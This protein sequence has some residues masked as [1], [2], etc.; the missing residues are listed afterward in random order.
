MRINLNKFM[1]SGFF[2]PILATLLLSCAPSVSLHF[3][4]EPFGNNGCQSPRSAAI[5]K[6]AILPFAKST[7]RSHE[8]INPISSNTVTAMNVQNNM[9]R[10][11]FIENDGELATTASER[12]LT[13][14]GKFEIVER[15]DI[16]N[17]I[18]EQKFMLSGLISEDDVYK[19]GNLLGADAILVGRVNSAYSYKQ[20]VSNSSGA[21]LT[22]PVSYVTVSVKLI[23]TRSGKLLWSCVGQRNSLNYLN[24][25]FTIT[26]NQVLNGERAPLLGI[27]GVGERVLIEVLGSLIQSQL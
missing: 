12:I 7:W 11:K 9:D 4:P 17:V 13:N 6:I 20:M 1:Q 16:M 15:Q 21:F 3:E 27:E 19:V 14:S 8:Y 24:K 26:N 25:S 22:I 23:D 2:I 10:Y 5:H 18:N